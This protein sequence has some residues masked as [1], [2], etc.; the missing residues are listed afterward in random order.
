MRKVRS[1]P[2]V[3]YGSYSQSYSGSPGS[4]PNGIPFDVPS[5]R[6]KAELEWIQSGTFTKR[7][8]DVAMAGYEVFESTERKKPRFNECMHTFSRS[9]N[10][11]SSHWWLPYNSNRPSWSRAWRFNTPALT[12]QAADNWAFDQIISTNIQAEAY[13]TMLPRFEGD[14]SMANFIFEMKDFR[15]I[16]RLLSGQVFKWCNKLG[17]RFT[18]PDYLLT[19]TKRLAG[20]HLTNSFAIEPFTADLSQ[21][22]FQAQKLVMDVQEEFARKGLQPNVRHFSKP[23][24]QSQNLVYNN[25]IGVRNHIEVYQGSMSSSM[26]TATME[27]DYGYT[28][29]SSL[30]AFL[31]YWGLQLTAEAVWNAIPFSFLVDYFVSIGHSLNVM[32]H[33]TNVRY[34]VRQYSESLLSTRDLGLFIKAGTVDHARRAVMVDDRFYE[35]GNNRNIYLHTNGI[36]STNYKRRVLHPYWGPFLPRWKI[37]SGKQA[38]NMLALLRCLL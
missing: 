33:D 25:V 8:D 14:I 31:K 10:Y 9:V 18:E 15:D 2:T 11:R 21:I 35:I 12:Y 37:P 20:L 24:D 27:G 36:H 28:S 23:L 3:D 1:L 30:D 34:H 13:H 5:D 32:R 6:I 38:L 26:F 4:G 29:R 19:G 17:L 7:R 16:S 22:L